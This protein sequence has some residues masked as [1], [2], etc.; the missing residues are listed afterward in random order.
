MQQIKHLLMT[1]LWGDA[2]ITRTVFADTHLT[3][4]RTHAGQ[5]RQV[6]E[7]IGRLLNAK[8]PDAKGIRDG[9]A[10]MGVNIET[11]QQLVVNITEEKPEF[12][13]RDEK[14]WDSLKTQIQLLGIFH[15]T[16]DELM[17]ADDMK[18]NRSLL[19]AHAKGLAIRSAM[20]QKTAT[21]LQR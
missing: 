1:A 14:D 3:D 20:L 12:M 8:Q 7:D 10:A 21:R 9:I 18:T 19:R 13:V 5:V 11:L 6:S 2:F 16:K 17:K 15:N 4:I